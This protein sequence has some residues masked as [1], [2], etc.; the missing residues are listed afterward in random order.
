[1]PSGVGMQVAMGG[2]GLDCATVGDG[3]FGAERV[4][5]AVGRRRVGLAAV[6][7]THLDV[8]KRQVPG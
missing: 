3:G 4:A 6:S 8:Y 5:V 2:T 7:Y 1:M